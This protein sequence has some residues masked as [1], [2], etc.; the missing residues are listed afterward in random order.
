MNFV[1]EHYILSGIPVL[2]W[3]VE[4]ALI[5]LLVEKPLNFEVSISILIQKY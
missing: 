2:Q 1:S 4:K 3:H 5:H